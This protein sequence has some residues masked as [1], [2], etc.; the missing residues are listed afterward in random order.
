MQV[1]S[2]A[3]F[4][5][6][7]WY[8]TTVVHVLLQNSEGSRGKVNNFNIDFGLARALQ[9][10]P[11]RRACSLILMPAGKG[12]ISL[13]P[14]PPPSH[15]EK[16][17]GQPSRISWASTRQC[18]LAVFYAKPAHQMIFFWWSLLDT[19]A[20]LPIS[21]PLQRAEQCGLWCSLNLP[22]SGFALG[23]RLSLSSSV[24]GV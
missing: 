7:T 16:Q 23:S 17:S 9:F 6:Q 12:H 8:S 14:R 19:L 4:H 20:V 3:M 24:W 22:S 10:Y 18:H 2:C 5:S 1:T 11:R 21:V 15:E 13:V